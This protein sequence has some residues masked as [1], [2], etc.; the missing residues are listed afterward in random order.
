MG[1]SPQDTVMTIWHENEEIQDALEFFLNDACPPEGL[2]P[3]SDYWVAMCL[4]NP[5]W[6]AQIRERLA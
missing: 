6:A 2:L 5:T 3:E 4:T 1:P